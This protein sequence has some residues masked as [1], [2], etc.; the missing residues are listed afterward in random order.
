MLATFA[1]LPTQSNHNIVCTLLSIYVNLEF[2]AA[3]RKHLR[4]TKNQV[5]VDQILQ[6]RTRRTRLAA[7]YF[8]WC[9][10]PVKLDSRQEK[11]WF[12]WFEIHTIQKLYLHILFQFISHHTTILNHDEFIWSFVSLSAFPSQ[13]LVTIMAIEMQKT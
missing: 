4:G 6:Y 13:V 5:M 11:K 8:F 2:V 9:V 12:C 7:T 3:S 1:F 10:L